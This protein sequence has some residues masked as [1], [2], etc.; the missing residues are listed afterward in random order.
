MCCWSQI[1]ITGKVFSKNDTSP[2]LGVLITEKGTKNT[3]TTNFDG[4]FSIVVSHKNSILIFSFVGFITKEIS[5][6][7]RTKIEVVLQEAC[8]I[9]WFDVQHI[10]FYINSGTIH[11]P[12]GGQFNF[13]FPNIFGQPSLKSGIS[14]QTNLKSNRFSNIFLNLHHL[15]VS[16]DFDADINTSYRNLSFENNLKLTTYSIE[17]SLN[18]R[19]LRFIVGYSNI[20][21]AKTNEL[22]NTKST[23]LT[24]GIGSW[25]SIP[26]LMSVTGKVSIYRNL[27]AYQLEINKQYRGIYTFLKAY[28]V[29]DF[30]ELSLGIGIEITYSLKNKK[31]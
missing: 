12:I 19:P 28:K 5:L 6:K 17:T 11:N 15:F 22:T 9:D 14:Y 25:I 2:L 27:A 3:A 7:R 23:G 24:L 1:K 16:C 8:N 31:K 4:K 30:T 10:G 20:D 18:W 26:F 13:T 21:F 29:N